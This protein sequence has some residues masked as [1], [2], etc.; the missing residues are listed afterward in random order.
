MKAFLMFRDTDVDNDAKGAMNEAEL[1]E[2]LELTTL[3][4]AMASGDPF[5]LRVARQALL[6]SLTDQHVIRYRQDVLRDWLAQP[7]L[8]HDLYD[9]AVQAVV[10]EHEVY[11]GGIFRSPETTL[12]R[13]V[14]VLELFLE[15][16]TKLRSIA[17][18]HTGTIRSDGLTQFF[19]MLIK[20]LD[21]DYFREIRT[22][23]RHL[24]FR[25]GVLIS[26]DLGPELAGRAYTLRKPLED[27][28]TWFERLT[29]KGPARFTYTVSERDEAGLRSLSELRNRGIDLVADALAQSTDHILSFFTMMRA[30]LGFYL[31]CVNLHDQLRARSLPTCFPEPLAPDTP[32]LTCRALY[33]PCLALRT[34]RPVAGNDVNARA[35]ALIMITGANQG[36]KSTFLRS[37]GV[38]QLML[39]AG[40]F[41]PAESFES[42]LCSGIFTHYPREEDL[43]MTSGKLDEELGRMSAIVDHAAAHSLILCN[44]SFA[45]TN[46]REG[47]EIAR[48]ITLALIESRIR[49]V[50]VT[51]LFELAHGLYVRRRDDA[52]FLRAPRDTE[53]RRSFQLIEG[54]PLPT[55]F[56]RDL[57]DQ[58]FPATPAWSGSDASGTWS[59]HASPSTEG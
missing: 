5:L 51:H 19:S 2:D 55:S 10:G 53:G 43:T 3:L 48:Q 24:R 29:I 16:L 8:L 26:A 22:H 18:D 30:E 49:V 41:A 50:F 4:T 23:L 36:G 33:D 1:T 6:G 17:D 59:P 35:R 47:S 11:P 58:I 46:E 7:A 40:M 37:V 13:S 54:E 45:A 27:R 21:D 15:L 39:Q 34:D 57:Y 31:A 20:E 52:L 44:E 28:R 42:S 56:G 32:M 38:A 12:H 14:T 25:D 9:L